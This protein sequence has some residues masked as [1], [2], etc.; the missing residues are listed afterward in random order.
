M[1][2]AF[3]RFIRKFIPSIAKLSYNPVAKFLLDGPD[4][5]IDLAFP[6]YRRLPPNHLRVRVGVGNELFNNHAWYMI[7]ARD[8]WFFILSRSWI[9]MD[10][11]IVDIG[12][13]CGKF[14]HHFRDY[15]YNGSKFR[16]KYIGIDID[17]E[18]LGWCRRHFDKERFDFHLSSHASKVYNDTGI[19]EPYALPI[20][21]SS[22]DLVF[23]T[24]LF[25]HLLEPE[26]LNYMTESFRVLTPNAVMV[27]NCF[28]ID[29]PPNTFGGRHTFRFRMGNAFVE[30]LKFPEAAVAY[31][32]KFLLDMAA[33]IGFRNCELVVTPGSGQPA[34]VCQK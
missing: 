10:S 26:I 25:T 16:G 2:F 31:N 12:C 32:S 28:L 22:V 14:A 27:M 9:T 13:G 21:E 8:F 6:V 18:A 3:D 11:T 23:S 24:S 34:L 7:G 33:E 4:L 1:N 15:N 20:A 5:V 29:Y 30:S 17:A 19:G